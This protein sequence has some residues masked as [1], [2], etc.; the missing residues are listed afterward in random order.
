MPKKIK[1][2]Y[3]KL[4]DQER[5]EYDELHRKL[6]EERP[7]IERWASRAL[8]RLDAIKHVVAALRKVRNARGIS[9][10]EVEEASGMGR[11]NVS[12]LEN[13]PD[14]NPTIETLMMYAD[15][16]GVELKI[17]IVDKK[18]GTLIETAA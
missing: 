1:R 13:A 10:S 12:R 9:L 4:S 16:I 17:A 2:T 8:D 14:P 6:D 15:A 18:A 5:A 7:E 11:A 3:R